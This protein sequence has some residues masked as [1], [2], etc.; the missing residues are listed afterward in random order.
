MRVHSL[1]LSLPTT[2]LLHIALSAGLSA[3]KTPSCHA[4][5]P[6]SSSPHALSSAAAS[7]CPICSPELNFLAAD[8]PYAHHTKSHV[9]PDVVVLPNLRV[10][11]RARLD[12]YSR[13]TLGVAADD[14]VKDLVTGEVFAT[15]EIKKVYIS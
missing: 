9:E 14:R 2:P 7:I 4:A 3:L 1:L 5:A 8:V 10:Y 15:D 13:K 6:P 11:S 12:D